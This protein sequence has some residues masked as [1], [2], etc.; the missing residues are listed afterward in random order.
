MT[1]DQKFFAECKKFLDIRDTDKRKAAMREFLTKSS[2]DGINFNADVH[3][4]PSSGLVA[5]AT[6]AKAIKYKKSPASSLSLG[7]AFFCYL[8]RD[9][10]HGRAVGQRAEIAAVP[11]T[12]KRGKRWNNDGIAK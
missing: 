4:I 9:L 10:Q 8:A 6:M 11:V 12:T 3:A 7:A 1:P 2:G 5:C